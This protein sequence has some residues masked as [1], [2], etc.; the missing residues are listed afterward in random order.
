LIPTIATAW[1]TGNQVTGKPNNLSM[2]PSLTTRPPARMSYLQRLGKA[3]I[4]WMLVPTVLGV[5]LLLLLIFGLIKPF[6]V[7]TGGMT[8]AITSGDH[9]VM[10]GITFLRRKPS[11]GD[12]V[13]FKTDGIA[14]LPSATIFV[15]RLAGKPREQLRISEGNLF[16]NGQLVILSNVTG[17]IKYLLPPGALTVTTNVTV[18]DGSYFV[19]GDNS[20][21]SFDSRFWGFVP[22]KNIMGRISFCYWPP[23]R[24]GMVK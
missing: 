22:R 1:A 2:N 8:P 4:G 7:P 21:N 15:K 19:L 9:V 3:G 24:I 10:E 23:K 14:E 13:V 20:T 18:P 12:I 16:I 17:Q 11:R 6:L 5:T